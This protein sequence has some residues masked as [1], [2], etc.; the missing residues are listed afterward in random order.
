M[1]NI[2]RG[3]GASRDIGER[4]PDVVVISDVEQK[5]NKIEYSYVDTTWLAAISSLSPS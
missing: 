5:L 2:C 4:R 3:E 1:S